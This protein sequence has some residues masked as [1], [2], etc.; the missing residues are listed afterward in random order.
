MRALALALLAGLA[1]AC[2]FQPLGLWPLTLAA[3]ALLL[4]LVR[5]A[6]GLS[7]ALARGWWFGVGHFVLGLNWIATAFTYQ[8]EMPAS[9]GYVAVV[10]LACYLAIYPAAATGLAWRWGRKADLRLI[11]IFAAAW[12][13]TEWLRATLFTGFAWNPLGVS[14]LATP[15]AHAARLVGTY[16]LSALAVVA[17]GVALLLAL[18]RWRPAATAAALVVAAAVAGALVAGPAGS[19]RGPALRIVQPNI[20]QQDKWREDFEDENLA[21]LRRYSARRGSGPRLLLWPEAA[22]TRPLENGLRDPGHVE[23]VVEL[24]RTVA[25]MLGESDL[26]LTGGVTWRSPDGREVTSATNSVFAMDR[27]G[28][29][30]GRYDKAHLVPYGEYLPMRPILSA[31]GLSRLAPGDIDFDPGPGARSL[32]LPLVGRVGF[33]LCYEIIFSGEVV[34]RRNRPNF[35]FN[36]SNDAWFGAWGPPQHL[37]QARLRAIEEGLPVLR[38][39]PTG[40]S[41]VIDADGRLVAS[42]PWRKAGIINSHLPAPKPATPF[43]RFG[44]ALPLLFALLLILLAMFAERIA[45]RRKGG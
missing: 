28:R 4:W 26:L 30:L 40:I 12:I 45:G 27:S 22:V 5:E 7:S 1:A 33:Q 39:T 10:L 37:A 24:R 13:V 9:L 2:G 43:A 3:L 23:E 8:A 38:A 32:D 18:R 20:G 11:L 35:L 14:L 44:N 17:A 42:L 34:D 25:A 15:V 6:P 41:A 21:R 29:V 16:G 31:L 19:P 36:P